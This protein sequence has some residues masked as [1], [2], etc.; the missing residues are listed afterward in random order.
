MRDGAKKELQI[1]YCLVAALDAE[2][3]SMAGPQFEA[4]AA[5]L[6]MSLADVAQRWALLMHLEGEEAREGCVGV[7]TGGNRGRVVG[8]RVGEASC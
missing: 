4:L 8:R 7:V 6:R 1:L 5:Q 3:W 2:G